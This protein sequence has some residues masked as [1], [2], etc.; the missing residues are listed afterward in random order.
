MSFTYR[1]GPPIS[2]SAWIVR[3]RSRSSLYSDGIFSKSSRS[4]FSSNIVSPDFLTSSAQRQ[5]TARTNSPT[6]QL[7]KSIVALRDGT[8]GDHHRPYSNS[9]AGGLI[10]SAIK[11][12]RAP[13]LESPIDDAPLPNRRFEK[14]LRYTFHAA[15]AYSREETHVP[16]H[17]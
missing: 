11:R 6:P 1:C 5:P 2:Q 12:P 7:Y 10:R 3:T 17:P 9:T 4:I 16:K 8:L 13:P 14:M 15:R